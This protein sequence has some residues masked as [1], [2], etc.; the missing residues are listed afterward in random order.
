MDVSASASGAQK[1]SERAI[2][3][4][5]AAGKDKKMPNRKLK[6]CSPSPYAF[7]RQAR[8]AKKD[9]PSKNKSR[10]VKV[11]KEEVHHPAQASFLDKGCTETNKPVNELEG[12]AKEVGTDYD[13]KRGQKW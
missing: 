8:K 12:K 2:L 4:L 11:E 7:V 3:W 13:N 9:V 5:K 1:I 6:R 10:Q